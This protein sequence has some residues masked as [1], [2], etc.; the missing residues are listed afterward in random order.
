[1]DTLLS[2]G[3][4]M[5]S[6][7]RLMDHAATLDLADFDDAGFQDKLERARRQS[8]GR[9]T[10]MGRL[11]GQMRNLLTV[12]TFAAG[13]VLYNRWLILLLRLARVPACIGAAHF[14]AQNQALDFRRTPERREL[15]HVRQT[16]ARVESAKEVRIFGLNQFLTNRY[17]SLSESF[18]AANRQIARRGALW[19]GIFTGFGT[20][21]VTPPM[22]GSSRAPCRAP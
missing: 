4:G 11:F 13:L 2:D 6:S 17:R 19:G 3:L 7:I 16:A 1:M 8:S 10:L 18:Y 12:A 5:K 21:G 20:L 14:N 22:S 15:D 9:M